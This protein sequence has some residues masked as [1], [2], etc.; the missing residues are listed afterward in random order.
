MFVTFI[1]FF[2]NRYS[3][4]HY[5]EIFLCLYLGS[6][7]QEF[8]VKTFGRKNHLILRENLNFFV[9][10]LHF[11]VTFLPRPYF[12]TNRIL[13]EILHFFRENTLLSRNF[14][15]L[16]RSYFMTKP[17]NYVKMDKLPSYFLW[18][19]GF[20]VKNFIN[21]I[22]SAQAVFYHNIVTKC[23]P[24]Y[25]FKKLTWAAFYPGPL[26]RIFYRPLNCLPFRHRID[27]SRKIWAHFDEAKKIL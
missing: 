2:S 8:Y 23:G 22:L 1:I 11:H 20:F 10:T 9:K 16:R 15:C 14:V 25:F 24:G 6:R 27:W 19:S 13:C 5:I 3:N 7:I 21:I 26:G 17:E 12:I 18:K 4:L